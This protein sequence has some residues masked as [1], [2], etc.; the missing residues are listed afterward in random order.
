[1]G[2]CPATLRLSGSRTPTPLPPGRNAIG[3]PPTDC[4]GQIPG[5]HSQQ[6]LIRTGIEETLDCDEI[7][8]ETPRV[9][10]GEPASGE[11]GCY[12]LGLACGLNFFPGTWWNQSGK[13]AVR[14]SSNR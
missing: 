13:H 14:V 11:E 12:L 7:E 8:A 4:R 5:R 1:M 6:M 10:D 9:A 2:P 3:E